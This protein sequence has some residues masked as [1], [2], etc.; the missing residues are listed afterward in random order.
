MHCVHCCHLLQCDFLI[1]IFKKKLYTVNKLIV[2]CGSKNQVAVY[3]S[4]AV[5]QKTIASDFCPYLYNILNSF[6][7]TKIDQVH[8]INKVIQYYDESCIT[9][10]RYVHIVTSESR[11]LS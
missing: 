7:N 6:L 1:K 8:S 3:I 2:G 11:I 10:A 9:A 4:Y 5:S